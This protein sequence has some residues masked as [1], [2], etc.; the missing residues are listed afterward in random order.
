MIVRDEEA[1]LSGCLE[2]IAG[3]FDEIIVVDTG[4]TDATKQV[5]RRFGAK[6]FDFPWIDDFAAARNES[7]RYATGQWIFWLDADDRVDSIN[8]ARLAKV[9]ESLP[10]VS[11]QRNPVFGVYCN[12]SMP[13]F[14]DAGVFVTHGRLF[15][16]RPDLQWTGRIH[17]RLV[18][19]PGGS[20]IELIQTD[21][22]IHHEGYADQVHRARK[23]Q[24]N[25][26]LIEH[27]YLLDPDDPM[28]LFY[29]A[30]Q[31]LWAGRYD[32]CY[33]LARRSIEN[34]PRNVL[35]TTPQC[36]VMAADCRFKTRRIEEAVAVT[37]EGL[38]RC[39]D[40]MGIVHQRG[41]FLRELRRLDEATACLERVV[42]TERDALVRSGMHVE[43]QLPIARLTL[44]NI[45]REQQKFIAAERQFRHVIAMQP[46]CAE[47]HF[48]LGHLLLWL[49][50]HNEAQEFIATL[51]RM[52]GAEYERAMLEGLA[53]YYRR[54]LS[55]G[56]RWIE[57][58]IS[59]RPEKTYSW[60]VLSLLLFQSGHDWDRCRTVHEKVLAMDPRQ[61]EVRQR[62]E[63]VKAVLAKKAARAAAGDD[64]APA[65]HS[66]VMCIVGGG[67][68]GRLSHFC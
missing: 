46:Q 6:V 17:E 2:G 35:P 8:R 48:L 54:D 32:D 1:N 56:C 7:R 60:I 21:V 36:F 25:A 3:L 42:G 61:S 5:A 19:T 27:E 66:G 55:A 24:R 34:D 44:G 28:T 47:A 11:D 50:R 10:E 33:R 67:H 14:S 49:G 51:E 58:A 65:D 39:P 31:R 18:P 57:A 40:H 68:G 9:I 29:L 59:L 22:T 23:I 43:T 41:C 52:A 16:N 38:K 45:Y 37:E 20:I 53:R 4:S 30:R 63:E 64:L 26:R 15:P 12:C 62:L 13:D